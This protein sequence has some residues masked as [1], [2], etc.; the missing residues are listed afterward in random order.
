MERFSDDKSLETPNTMIG[1]LPISLMV[2]VFSSILGLRISPIFSGL[3]FLPLVSLLGYPLL[4]KPSGSNPNISSDLRDDFG[5]RNTK[6][7]SGLSKQGKELVLFRLAR[8]HQGMLTI[9]RVTLESG[10]ALDEVEELL[11]D[12]YSRGY[13]ECIIEDEGSVLYTFPD[14]LES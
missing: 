8:K 10:L 7:Q 9:P 5:L 3:I 6:V 13:C 14:F 4:T 12:L 1:F 2:L 11:Q